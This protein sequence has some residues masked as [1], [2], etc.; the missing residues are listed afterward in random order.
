MKE[1]LKQYVNIP[2]V[3]GREEG[4]ANALKSKLGHIF[5]DVRT[6]SIGSLIMHR[7]GTGKKLLLCA[8]IDD[9]GIIVTYSENGK[10]VPGAL[11][12]TSESTFSSRR[13]G[14][15]DGTSGVLM[16]GGKDESD[17][18]KYEVFFGDSTNPD[19][20]PVLPKQSERGYFYPEFNELGTEYVTGRGIKSKLGA[21]LVTALILDEYKDGSLFSDCDVTLIFYVQSKLDTKGITAASFGIS[22]DIAVIFDYTDVQ[23]T[24]LLKG[25]LS[26]LLTSKRYVCPPEISSK[27]QKLISDKS[28]QVYTDNESVICPEAAL[29]CHASGFPVCKLCFAVKD[30]T[31]RI[32]DAVQSAKD[33]LHALISE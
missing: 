27:L 9:F 24:E 1:I 10:T 3:A 5:E 7:S 17:I 8:P 26:L 15:F 33:V 16:N 2:S 4:M 29:Y 28:I 20:N 30:E 23:S 13:V 21:A 22:A 12:N 11:G 31:V 18:S 6:D 14:F 25:G 19:G 32:G